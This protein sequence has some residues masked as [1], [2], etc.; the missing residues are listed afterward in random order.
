MPPPLPPRPDSQTEKRRQIQM[1]IIQTE[2]EHYEVLRH[3]RKFYQKPL[4]KEK[5]FSS[6]QIDIIFGNIKELRIIHKKIFVK[7]NLAYKQHILSKSSDAYYLEE[8]LHE[9][10]C[11]ELGTQLE[12]EASK[13]CVNRKIRNGTE[14][15]NQRKKDN[16][17]RQWADSRSIPD[18]PFARLGLDDLLSRVF[19]RPLRYPL[20]FE[21]LLKSTPKDSPGYRYLEQV[22]ICI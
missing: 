20:L 15:W 22:M 2:E 16:R 18:N 9:I 7:M 13:F 1:E 10:F 21:R 11:G 4:K 5:L 6:E 8:T 3:I 17:L 19:Q 12:Q 14:L